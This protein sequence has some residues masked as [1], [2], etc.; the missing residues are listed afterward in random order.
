MNCIPTAMGCLLIEA[1]FTGCAVEGHSAHEQ[2]INVNDSGWDAPW[3][4]AVMVADWVVVSAPA[5]AVKAGRG[6]ACGYRD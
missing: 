5:V 6:G 2:R 4:V 3:S 1:G